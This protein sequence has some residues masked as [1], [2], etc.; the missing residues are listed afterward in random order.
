[1]NDANI[2]RYLRITG[3]ADERTLTLI[4][5]CKEQ[6]QKELSPVRLYQVY[7]IR[8]TPGGVLIADREFEGEKIRKKLDGCGKCALLAVTLG[9]KSDLLLRRYSVSQPA[10][11]VVMQAV[12]ADYVEDF[13]DLTETEIA[14]QYPE[15]QLQRRFSPGYPGF[16]LSYQK[17]IFSMMELSKR[18]GISLT[19]SDL[20]IP[21]K[22]V[23]AFAG[24]KKGTSE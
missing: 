5:K 19:D 22:S 11:A 7:D 1:M 3:K 4:Q 18:I 13:C 15:Y 14:R 24:L 20:M 10:K 21:T 12:L 16:P 17:Q 2:L 6:A 9:A 23:T 8:P